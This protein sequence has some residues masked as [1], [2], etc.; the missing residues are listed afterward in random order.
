M[1]VR[2][3]I[4]HISEDLTNR[5]LAK[6]WNN[7]PLDEAHSYVNRIQKRIAKAVKEGKHRLAR[8][9][10]YLLTHSFFARVLAVKR[11]LETLENE[12][13]VWME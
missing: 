4:T 2:C 6:Q 9:L 7:L 10:Q 5:E 3:S 11:L 8:R 1:D 13:R 12:L